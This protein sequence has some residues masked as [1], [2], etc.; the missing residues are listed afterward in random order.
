VAL[1]DDEVVVGTAPGCGVDALVDDGWW[2]DCL[3][4]GV[5]RDSADFDGF[6]TDLA[7]AARA[8]G[9]LTAWVLPLHDP[10]ADEVVGCVVV[11][12]R[13]DTPLNISSD[14]GLQQT[15]RL[16]TLVI[17]EQRRHVALRRAALTDP[18]TGVANRSALRRRLD[19][20][21]GPVTV[22]FV[23]LDDFKAVN[24]G[25]GHDAGDLVL[26]TVAER[27]TAAVREGD[28]VVR[29]GGDEFAVVVAD[30]PERE[31][32][33]GP[34]P[35]L[36]AQRTQAAVEGPVELAPGMTIPVHASVG[37]ATGAARDVVRK[38]DSALYEAKRAKR[39][40]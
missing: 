4:D 38:A 10:T 21:R 17:G 13:I 33:T 36:L 9:F 39:S 32:G 40:L 1:L 16:A 20:A 31:P 27:L 28:L 6:A 15:K 23:D 34:A 37:V 14:Q 7:E 25:Y 35:Y 26:T 12:V 19:A 24:D 8:A 11:W 22:V 5:L 2:R 29:L 18:L 30:D 3:A